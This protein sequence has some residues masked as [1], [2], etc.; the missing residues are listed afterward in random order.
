MHAYTACFYAVTFGCVVFNPSYRLAGTMYGA[1]KE[2]KMSMPDG[3]G[4][5]MELTIPSYE[6]RWA[7][8]DEMANDVIASLRYVCEKAEKFKIEITSRAQNF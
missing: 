5:M 1:T 3:K 6:G 2:S 4:G 7:T 8:A